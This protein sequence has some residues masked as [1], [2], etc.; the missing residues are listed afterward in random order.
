[1]I[2]KAQISDAQGIA[3]IY[4][5]GSKVAYSD[6][7]PNKHLKSLS[8]EEK[9][10]DYV[11]RIS[12]QS[13]EIYVSEENGVLNGFISF[14]RNTR[15]KTFELLQIYVKPQMKNRGIGKKLIAFLENLAKT[16]KIVEL[17]LWV[18]KGNEEALS[19]YEK[20]GFRDDKEERLLERYGVQQ[21]RLSKKVSV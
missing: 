19:F 21:I 14:I 12:S 16:D 8:L 20:M 5:S 10:E 7:V 13:E 17:F 9:T 4:I 18:I 15:P 3:E 11:S 1:M 6:V 2:R